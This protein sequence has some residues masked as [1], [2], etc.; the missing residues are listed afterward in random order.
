LKETIP[1]TPNQIKTF[2][3]ISRGIKQN[4]LIK[5]RI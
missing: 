2:R 5:L 3:G 1:K 4:S